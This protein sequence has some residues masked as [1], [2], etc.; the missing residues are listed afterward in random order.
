MRINYCITKTMRNEALAYMAFQFIIWAKNSTL[1]HES[2]SQ[3]GS[4]FW[5]GLKDTGGDD[6]FAW[7]SKQSV[8]ADMALHW[9]G[10]E[11]SHKNVKGI[12]LIRRPKH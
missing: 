7:R 4:G 2:G 11:P 6:I 1:T 12:K 10:G 8:S 3:F 9:G 5:I